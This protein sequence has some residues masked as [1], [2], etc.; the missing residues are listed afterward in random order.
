MCRDSEF[1]TYDV[2]FKEEEWQNY[3]P[4]LC[5]VI[6]SRIPDKGLHPQGIWRD[7]EV[8]DETYMLLI[9]P[10]PQEESPQISGDIVVSAVPSKSNM[11]WGDTHEEVAV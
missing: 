6:W 3:A 9:S 11:K 5:A 2:D 10:Q 1:K 7:K 4:K 8:K